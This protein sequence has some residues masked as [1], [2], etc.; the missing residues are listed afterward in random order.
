MKNENDYL[1]KCPYYRNR[2]GTEIGCEGW[3]EGKKLRIIFKNKI[4]MICW[5]DESCRTNKWAMCPYADFLNKY[6]YGVDDG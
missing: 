4:S 5:L 2:Y 6:K 3:D 1:V